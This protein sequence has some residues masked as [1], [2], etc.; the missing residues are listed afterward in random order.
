[1][2]TPLLSTAL[3]DMPVACPISA[4][5]QKFSIYLAT[6]WEPCILSKSFKQILLKKQQ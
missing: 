2:P 3:R 6:F 4:Y 1:L 5:F